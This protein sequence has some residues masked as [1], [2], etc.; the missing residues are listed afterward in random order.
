[1]RRMHWNILLVWWDLIGAHFDSVAGSPGADDNASAVAGMLEAA[2][3]LQA[4]FPDVAVCYAAFNREEEGLI[5][6]TEISNDLCSGSF[7]PTVELV[8]V[9]EMIGFRNTAEHSQLVPD[10]L[11]AGLFPTRGDFLGL[12]GNH[13]SAKVVQSVLEKSATYTP[14]VPVRCLELPPGAEQLPEL[15]VVRR[16]DHAPFWDLNV[17][18][19]MWTDTAEFRNFNYHTANDLP[20]TLDYDFLAENTRLL[21]ASVAKQ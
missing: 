4:E 9:L 6:S 10:G 2:R 3:I 21:I 18:A 15:G 13:A 11:P 5:G 8:H 1:M 16:S 20:D 12:L 14:N 17:P 19:L 7:G